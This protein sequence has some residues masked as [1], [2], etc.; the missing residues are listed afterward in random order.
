[1]TGELHVGIT[2]QM[3]NARLCGLQVI[4]GTM[5]GEH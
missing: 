3:G 1:L 2:P 4:Q 5:E